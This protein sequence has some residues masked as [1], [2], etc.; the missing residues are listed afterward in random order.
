ML[1]S[2]FLV[3]SWKDGACSLGPQ[4]LELLLG[5]LAGQA[6]RHGLRSKPKP[7]GSVKA[8]SM[9]K[10]CTVSSDFQETLQELLY[11]REN[12]SS[13]LRISSMFV[14]IYCDPFGLYSF[15]SGIYRFLEE[16]FDFH[17]FLKSCQDHNSSS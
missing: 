13:F 4:C 7:E 12:C 1:H 11:L 6:G 16:L 14:G 15:S 17:A 9:L 3:F 5:P 8:T 10:D 2:A